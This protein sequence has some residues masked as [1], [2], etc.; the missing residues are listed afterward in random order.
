M[1]KEDKSALISDLSS[2]LEEYSHFYLADIADLDSVKSSNLRRECFNKDI[3]LIVVKNTLLKK[4]LEE[5]EKDYS[6]LY[7]VLK[8]NT[9]VMFSNTGNGPAKLIKEF[10][11]KA[12]KPVLK[13]AFVEE[14]CYVGENQLDFLATIKSKDE[15]I[16]DLIALLQ[17]PAKNVIS[18]LQGAAG[19]KI[20]GLLKAMEER[21]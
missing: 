16:G 11:K 21:E 6:E 5:S 17:S 1:K 4:A 7:P 14:S 20:H 10:R 12:D 9:S 15:L 18:G 3:K 19:G 2:K 13:A 8:G